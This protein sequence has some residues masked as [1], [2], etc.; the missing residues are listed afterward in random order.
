MRFVAFPVTEYDAV[1]SGCQPG[2]MVELNHLTWLIAQENFAIFL[3]QYF[4]ECKTAM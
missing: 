4:V 3:R 1:L 2:Q